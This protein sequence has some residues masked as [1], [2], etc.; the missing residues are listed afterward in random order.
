MNPLL[1]LR[2]HNQ[3][4]WLDYIRRDLIAG[5]G[6]RAL[7]ENDGLRGVTSNPT[8]FEKAI[9]GDADYDRQI[10]E[11]LARNANAPASELYD[12]LAIEDVRNAADILRPSYDEVDGLDGFVSIEPPPQMTRDTAATVREAERLWHGVDRPNLMVKV[13][14][15]ADGIAAFET[16]IS[17]GINI[18]VTLMFSLQHYEAVAAA[19]IRGLGRCRRPERVASVASFFV[20]RVDTQVDLALRKIGTNEARALDGTIAIANAK[21]AYQ[22]FRDI[23]HGEPFSAQRKRG[24]RVQRPLWASTS[25]KNPRYSDVLYVEELIGPETVNTMPLA[26]LNAFRDHGR[27]RDDTLASDLAG[28]RASL[29]K[30][31]RLGVDLNAIAEKL[32]VDGITAFAAD[33][34]RVLAA[35]DSKKQSL[36]LA[37]SAG[38]GE[39]G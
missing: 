19:Y 35:I 39:R 6:L 13:V 10:S 5:P 27:V 4:V 15:S 24:A 34:D 29:E 30:L 20:S 37:S 3:A 7:V 21:L 12:A 33:Y 25:T 28:A 9:Q 11:L 38:R 32:Q 18:N 22:R 14:G 36:A 17:R 26:T 31:A 8:I 23:F 1:T 16:L 2:N